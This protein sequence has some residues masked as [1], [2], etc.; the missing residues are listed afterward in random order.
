[1]INGEEKNQFNIYNQTKLQE[2]Y[3]IMK[4]VDAF[5]QKKIKQIKY[6]EYQNA[7]QI[8]ENNMYLVN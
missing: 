5:M 6:E 2:N 7:K 1:M 3:K 4:D 8:A